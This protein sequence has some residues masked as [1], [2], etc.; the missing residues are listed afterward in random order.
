M[1][2]VDMKDLMQHA[3]RNRYAVGAFDV[4]SVDFLG[5]ILGAAERCRAP[6]VLNLEL[7]GVP[8][9]ELASIMPAVEAAAR[10]S[11]V[12]VAIHLRCEADAQANAEAM[13][14][15]ANSLGLEDTRAAFHEQVRRT[16]ACARLAHDCGVP[17]EAGL[18]SIQG[19]VAGT[20]KPAP[21]GGLP[22][23]A[24]ITAF[25]SKTEADFLSLSIPCNR[26]A[27]K[28]KPKLEWRRLKEIGVACGLPLAIEV[29][30]ALTEDQYHKLI[31]MG[32]AKIS[33]P[34]VVANAIETA[35]REAG[36][37]G[38][39]DYAAFLTHARE[40]L[41]EAVERCLRAWGAAGRAA[42]VMAQCQPWL[43][44][45]RLVLVS[46]RAQ[47]EARQ[48]AVLLEGQDC[49]SRVPGVRG[50]ELGSALD[51]DSRYQYCW[52]IR[53]TH[54]RVAE[55][56]QHDGGYVDCLEGMLRTVAADS[57]RGDFQVAVLA[58]EAGVLPL[59]SMHGA[60]SGPVLARLG[61]KPA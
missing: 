15:G 12:P 9:P 8:S 30:D 29:R 48:R 50:V 14:L 24:E 23:T 22:T 6:V 18:G 47:D 49:L 59:R 60:S 55:G 10:R 2:L 39:K 11:E 43:N 20:D 34:M 61:G 3:Y 5:S 41:Q 44:V 51:L 33:E 4:C 27:G 46:L 40:A 36:R 17:L 19:P 16:R 7:R 38:R 25:L 35:S 32:I 1:P 54:P 37:A 58:G 26:A 52:R 56:L 53:L 57:I 21:S 42:E 13:R 31:S 28:E 45:E